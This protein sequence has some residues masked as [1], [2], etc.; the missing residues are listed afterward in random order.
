[1]QETISKNEGELQKDRELFKNLNNHHNALKKQL[2][3]LTRER[4]EN[5]NVI[6]VLRDREHSLN[7]KLKNITDELNRSE[8]TNIK[9]ELRNHV[10]ARKKHL[11]EVKG[12]MD[13]LSNHLNKVNQNE[14]YRIKDNDFNYYQNRVESLDDEIKN[15]D[16]RLNDLNNENYALKIEGDTNK[17]HRAD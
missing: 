4:D 16:Q 12:V 1:M 8:G 2:E 13:A 7:D 10:E 3:Q 6:R 17:K 11:D 9:V 14:E 5:D 15:K